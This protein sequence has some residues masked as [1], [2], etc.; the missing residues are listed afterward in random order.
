MKSHHRVIAEL[1]P[2]VEPL[3]NM[4]LTRV[5]VIVSVHRMIILNRIGMSF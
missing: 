4:D 2:G 1:G 5:K 3:L